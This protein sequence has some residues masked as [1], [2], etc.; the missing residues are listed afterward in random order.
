MKALRLIFSFLLIISITACTITPLQIN[1]GNDEDSDIGLGGT[2]LLS[3]N[4]EDND[5]GLGGTGIIGKITG[6]GSIFVNGIEIEYNDKT[7]FTIDSKPGS[8]NQL[9]IGDIVEVLTLDKNNHTHAVSINL[10]HEIIGK[11][12]ETKAETFSFIINGQ[13][14]IQ[15][16][17]SGSLPRPGTTVAVSGYRVNAKT[18][19]STRV[20]PSSGEK[21]LVRM[22]IDLPFVGKTQNWLIQMHAQDKAVLRLKG[23]TH[24]LD[25]DDNSMTPENHLNI[26]ILNIQK[27][28]TDQLKLKQTIKP[29][30][31]PLGRSSIK[32]ERWMQHNKMLH[33]VQG[34]AFQMWQR[35]GT[36]NKNRQSG[37]RR[38]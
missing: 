34:E 28:N 18:I 12:E 3:K 35:T 9:K 25:I 23:S 30:N 11:V 38:K 37:N 33:P 26:R 6:Y 27:S 1:A 20:T 7:P 24:S 36:E 21:N 13:T 19:V 10:R 32:P 22:N 15:P 8:I 5:N 16:I 29:D 31:I 14:I 17:G 4:N 2:G